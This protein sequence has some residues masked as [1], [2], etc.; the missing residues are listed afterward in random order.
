MRNAIPGVRSHGGSALLLL[1]GALLGGCEAPGDARTSIEMWAMGREGEVVQALIPEFERRHPDIA[2]RVQQVPWSAAHEKLLT[3]FAG[4]TLPDVF[5]LGNTW[6]PEFATLRALAALDPWLGD[7]RADY[8]PGILDTNVIDG[9]TYGAPWYVDTRVLFYRRDLL[10][11]AGIHEFPR[12]WA[13]WS[14]TLRRLKDRGPAGSHPILLA[15]NEWEPPVILAV[16]RGAGLLRE[17][18]QFG[19]FGSP[20]FREAFAFYLEFFRRGHAPAAG[21]GR[22]AN[23]YQDFARGEFA[24]FL[25]GPWSL[26]ELGRRM[27]PRLRDSWMTA[28]LPGPDAQQPGVSLAGGASLVVSSRSRHPRAAWALIEFLCEPAQQLAFF[29]LSGDLPARR[30]AW[31]D[32]LLA[33]DPRIGAFRQQ[34]DHVAATPKIPEWER[35]AATISRYGEAVIRGGMTTDEALAALNRDV[36]AIL[37]KRRW[38]L[39]NRQAKDE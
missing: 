20:A 39:A 5:Q 27:P 19:D 18:A 17:R 38:L 24:M 7:A 23:L 26:G 9:R 30:S 35:I 8:F 6:V 1:L 15:L 25:S 12:T 29:R 16:Q 33:D 3:A 11:Q 28:P 14:E 22:L 31:L 36:D 34:L 32:P 10:K 2:V 21:A 37:E 13:Q 4:D